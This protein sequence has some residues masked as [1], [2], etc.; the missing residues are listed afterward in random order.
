M[1]FLTVIELPK[2]AYHIVK[3]P[4]AGERLLHFLAWGLTQTIL[5]LIAFGSELTV[6]SQKRAA[7]ARGLTARYRLAG[8]LA[9]IF[10]AVALEEV[11]FALFSPVMP[12][13]PAAG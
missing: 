3:T 13:I 8:I 7:W 1:R 12:A 9:S 2:S 10:I 11:I 5:A 6:F 4:S